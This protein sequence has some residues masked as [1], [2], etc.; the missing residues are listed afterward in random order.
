MGWF[1]KTRFSQSNRKTSDIDVVW[2]GGSATFLDIRK[3]GYLDSYQLP[4]D[5]KKQVPAQVA[6]IPLTDKAETWHGSALS[7]F[8][9]FYNR[10]VLA[11]E[12]MAEPKKWQDFFNP[13]YF[14][15]I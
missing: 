6:G 15:F 13:K 3:E 11:A 5:L 4:A 7:T 12:G 10:K 8:G 2:G 9:F 14:F 1:L